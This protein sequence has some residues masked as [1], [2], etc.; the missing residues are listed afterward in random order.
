LEKTR[1]ERIES[2]TNKKMIEQLNLPQTVYK[3]STA[4]LSTTLLIGLLAF[5]SFSVSATANDF[6]KF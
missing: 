3:R 4:V 2:I 1:K 6:S 5:P